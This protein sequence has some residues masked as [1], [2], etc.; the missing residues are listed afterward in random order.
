MQS[1]T[2][3]WI[4]REAVRPYNT[5]ELYRRKK[6]PFLAPVAGPSPDSVPCESVLRRDGPS[7]ILFHTCVSHSAVE[8]NA[9]SIDASNLSFNHFTPNKRGLSQALL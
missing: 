5:D 1:L 7:L 3:K 9:P 6:H 2:A 8:P 4:L